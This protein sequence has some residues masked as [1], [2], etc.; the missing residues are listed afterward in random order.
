MKT[1]VNKASR[2]RELGLEPLPDDYCGS[3]YG[4]SE[5]V[6]TRAKT[7]GGIH[8]KVGTEQYCGR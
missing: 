7:E 3:C 5:G 6:A 1:L 2:E 8:V 4:A